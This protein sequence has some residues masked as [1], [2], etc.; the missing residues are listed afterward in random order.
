MK[1]RYIAAWK[2]AMKPG[3]SSAMKYEQA[4]IGDP[5]LSMQKSRHSGG[6]T[7]FPYVGDEAFQSVRFKT[8]GAHRLKLPSKWK[9]YAAGFVVRS[10]STL[11][12]Y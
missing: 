11:G 10:S 3:Y 4:L 9:A 1:L 5:E 12:A 2:K 6:G 7:H 8:P